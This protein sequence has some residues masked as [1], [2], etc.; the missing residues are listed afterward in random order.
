MLEGNRV[1][2]HWTD[3]RTQMDLNVECVRGKRV[4]K[5]LFSV[6]LLSYSIPVLGGISSIVNLSSVPISCDKMREKR[7]SLS[8]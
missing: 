3:V 4:V 5:K 2:A 1:P 6:K 7:R 8:M